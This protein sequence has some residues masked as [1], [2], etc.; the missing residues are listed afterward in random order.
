MSERNEALLA[1]LAEELRQ[2]REHRGISLNSISDT[3]KI[4]IRFLR[5]IEQGDLNCIEEPYMRI[6]LKTY[7]REVGLDAAP[8]LERYDK[9]KGDQKEVPPVRKAAPPASVAPKAAEEGASPP[10]S[11]RTVG[12][13]ALGLLILIVVGVR[14]FSPQPE[15]APGTPPVPQEG[16]SATPVPSEPSPAREQPAPPVSEATAVEN[17]QA[18]ADSL[19]LEGTAR[20]E[21]WVEVRAGGATLFTGILAAGRTQVWTAEDT[22]TLTLGKPVGID[23]VLNGKDI[24]ED[25]PAHGTLHLRITRE[26]PEVLS[27]WGLG[28]APDTAGA[29]GGQ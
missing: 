19:R 4:N 6:F 20:E 16:P 26:G 22:L 11:N 21:T 2:E 8:I 24:V 12:I 3:T 29:P 7:A 14:L 18:R 1:S 9:I 27:S 13:L 23:L 10:M 17:E 28:A 5:A 25:W 15:D